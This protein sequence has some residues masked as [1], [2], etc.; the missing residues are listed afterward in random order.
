MR[1]RSP[2]LVSARVA[3]L[4]LLAALLLGCAAPS[5]R[6]LVIRPPDE[7]GYLAGTSL[8]VPYVMPET[9]LTD[10]SGQAF[11]LKTSPSTPVTLL[12][13]GYTNCPDV[14]SGVLADFAFALQGLEPGVRDRIGLV[15][16]TTDPARD[17]GPAIRKYLDRFDPAFIGLTGDLPTIKAAG[18]RVG[19]AIEGTTK[20]SSGGYEVGHG[21]QV[22]GFDGDGRGVVLWTPGTGR[23]DLQHDLGLLVERSG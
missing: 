17:S 20:L 2:I 16:V 11:N 22:I 15:M 3:V 1:N 13:F 14:C 18:E 21:A 4:G 12:F 9:T 6:P 23:A 19:V 7:A 8:P 10:T 5:D